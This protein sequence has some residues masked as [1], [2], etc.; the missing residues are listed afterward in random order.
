MPNS[1]LP[2]YQYWRHKAL[3]ERYAVRLEGTRVIGYKNLL[4]DDRL[5]PADLPHYD[6][7]TDSAGCQQLEARGGEFVLE[8]S[9]DARGHRLPPALIDWVSTAPGRRKSTL[10]LRDPDEDDPLNH[11]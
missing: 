9:A 8:S 11:V 6:Y 1:S 3:R 5:D 2:S 10:L 7:D 4:A